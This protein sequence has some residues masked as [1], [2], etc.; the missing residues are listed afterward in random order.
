[1]KLEVHNFFEAQP[2]KN[3][4]VFFVKSIVHD[5]PDDSALTIL[6]H[7]REAAGP[8]TRLFS[9]DKLLPYTCETTATTMELV[10]KHEGSIT[11]AGPAG[12]E[13]KSGMGNLIPY[14][15]SVMVRFV[16]CC[17]SDPP[18]A[19]CCYV[20]MIGLL[21]GQE[22]TLQ[23]TVDLYRKAGWEIYKVYQTESQGLFSSQMQSRPIAIP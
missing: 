15:M 18:P 2:I 22:R 14:L 23:H 10:K 19:D 20:Q 16:V 1:M 8:N 17:C 13:V 7:L 6:R 3:P 21:N 12:G 4:D 9:M 11:F 5:W